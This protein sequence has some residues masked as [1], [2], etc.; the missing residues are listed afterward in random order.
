M[1]KIA[2][3]LLL[4]MALLV[5]A[6][7]PGSGRAAAQPVH[8]SISCGA[9]GVEL[10]LCTDAVEEWKR[11]TGHE[12][13]IVSTPN[14]STDRLA[15]YLQMLASGTG[16]IDIMQIDV[17]W[18]GILA[19]HLIDLKPYVGDTPE[20]HFPALIENNTVDG[21]LVAMPWWADVGVLYYRKDLLEKHGF[22]PPQTWQEMAET[23]RAV[24]TAERAGG[25]RGMWGFVFQGKAYEGLTCNGLEWIDSFGGGTIVDEAGKITVNNP[26][27][28]EALTLARSWVGEITPRGVL[29]YDEEAARGVFQ[30]GNAVFMRN[31][32]YAWSLAQSEDS[33]VRGRVGVIPLPSGGP[34]G[35]RSGT[36][37]GWHLAI[38]RY[39]RHPKQAADLVAFLTS[40]EQQKK[41]AIIG[42]Y[43]PTIPAL[44]SDPE[45]LVA[46]P[47]FGDLLEPLRNATARPSRIVGPHYNRLSSDFWRAAHDILAGHPAK[48]R[49]AQLEQDLDRLKFRAGW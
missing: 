11:Q 17:V 44:Y 9:L 7:A 42:S 38:S 19:S 20:E 8:I 12:V 5:P 30:T 43:N 49:V 23:A 16:D 46:N 29:S 13:T 45:V 24:Q 33:P 10:K 18:A 36:L 4:A 21:R 22:A 41:R 27:A 2:A 32:P 48:E 39:T 28:I 37:G 47:F 31:W 35:K 15:L 26:R 40:A 3:S 25:N 14:S 1:W 6:W 34:G